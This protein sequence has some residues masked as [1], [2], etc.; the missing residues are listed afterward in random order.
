MADKLTEVLVLISNCIRTD[1]A[2]PHM[3]I[4]M[5]TALALLIIERRI[6]PHEQIHVASVCGIW[7][8]N[9]VHDECLEQN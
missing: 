9:Y 3:S 1:S 2:Q 4:K 5:C 8:Q 6:L 7:V